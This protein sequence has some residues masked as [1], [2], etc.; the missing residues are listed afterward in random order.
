MARLY[1]A[2]PTRPPLTSQPVFP[3]W[4]YRAS[5]MHQRGPNRTVLGSIGQEP[6]IAK[7]LTTSD[8]FVARR[9]GQDR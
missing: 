1:Q 8:Y 4:G 7:T 2:A 6:G 5:R 9:N 3:A